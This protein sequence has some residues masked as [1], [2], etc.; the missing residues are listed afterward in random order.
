MLSVARLALELKLGFFFDVLL[1]EQA[2]QQR[3]YR[4]EPERQ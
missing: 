3:G 4:A 2:Q 1:D